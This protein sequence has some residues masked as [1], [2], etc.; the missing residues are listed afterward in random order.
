MKV[1]VVLA[2]GKIYGVYTKERYARAISL[3]DNVEIVK[4]VLDNPIDAKYVKELDNER[5]DYRVKKRKC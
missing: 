2:K 4:M 1:W 5:V 3:F